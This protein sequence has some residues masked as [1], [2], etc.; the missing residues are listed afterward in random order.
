MRR[1]Q[2]ISS[3][4]GRSAKSRV[5]R[6]AL[7]IRGRRYKRTK[8]TR[9][10]KRRGKSE[11]SETYTRRWWFSLG[12]IKR[13]TAIAKILN[14]GEFDSETGHRRH[15]GKGIG[16]KYKTKSSLKNSYVL[17]A[18]SR[19]RLKEIKGGKGSKH[20]APRVPPKDILSQRGIEPQ[21]GPMKE[22]NPNASKANRQE[23]W[24]RR[25]RAKKCQGETITYASILAM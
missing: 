11:R 5:I 13:W 4:C 23:R 10:K 8:Q 3:S 1:R 19:S 15:G 14:G 12:M 7:K 17:K 25:A 24:A 18:M 9:N 20:V 6:I 2:K 21:P 22:D 16:M